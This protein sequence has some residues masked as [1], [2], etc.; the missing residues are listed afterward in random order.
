M[1]EQQVFDNVICKTREYLRQENGM[2]LR[3]LNSYLEEYMNLEEPIRKKFTEE[4]IHMFAPLISEISYNTDYY[5]L[6]TFL[7]YA[8]EKPEIY[9]LLLDYCMIDDTLMKETK[10]FLYFQFTRYNFLHPSVVTKEI[11]TLCDDLYSIIYQ[12]YYQEVAESYE[13][14]PKEERNNDLV[15]VFSSQVLN[16]AH[17]PTKTL[18]D[19]CYALE[20][21]LNKK[22]FIINTAEML[23]G[24]GGF[25][26][27]RT[28]IGSYASQFNDLQHYPYKD[29]R[30]MFFQCPQ[31]M[32][33]VAVIQQI[34]E[35]IKSE[36]PYFILNIG[37]NSIVSDICSNIVPTL[38]L[39]T[40]FSGRSTTR[41]QFQAIGRKINQ[42]DRD[43]IKKHNLG[44]DHIIESLFTFVFR[45]QTHSY[46]REELGLPQEGFVV[47][48]VGGRLSL[49]VDTKCLEIL[50]KL[51]EQGIYVAFVGGF[52]AFDKLSDTNEV[53]R[54]Y[55]INLGFQ[56]DVLAVDE[57][58]DLY[59]NPK[60]TGGGSSAAEAMFK[61]MPVVT[62]DYGDV[63]VA[64]GDDF[65]V[66]DWE[67]MFSQVL[68]YANDTEY[69]NMMS[70]K[71]RKR[72][73]RLLDTEGEFLKIIEEMER[74]PRF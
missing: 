23:N 59:L 55:A 46:T 64:A 12:A 22:V 44:E 39:A 7:L 74:S 13:K 28:S 52:D 2:N 38:T 24:Y 36:K 11:A 68:R 41:G 70:I 37:G 43:W 32:P 10:L 21:V 60:R 58:C 5:Y 45:E 3:D 56:E 34:I 14:I 51:M 6:M 9:K 61:G 20:T 35:V 63:G 54:K 66:A 49:E 48:L 33:Q 47:Q 31:E 62:F 67:E 27:F 30:F 15:F 16:T 1:E 17:A 53:F 40:V 19:R 73:A 69:Y 65:H 26:T 25:T 71:A 57:C 18:L 42:D 50:I 8:T 4:L 29:R 72:A